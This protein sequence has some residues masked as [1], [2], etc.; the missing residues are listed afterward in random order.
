MTFR[1]PTLAA[2]ALMLMA[3]SQSTSGTPIQ[4]TSVGL[5]HDPESLIIAATNDRGVID[6]Q[7]PQGRV[8]GLLLPAVQTLRVPAVA[9]VEMGRTVLTSV[10]IQPG[11]RGR[12]WFVDRRGQRLTLTIP[13][14]GARVR[15]VLTEGAPIGGGASAGGSTRIGIP[16]PTIV[17][18]DGDIIHGTVDLLRTNGTQGD[19]G[20][21][22]EGRAGTRVDPRSPPPAPRTTGMEP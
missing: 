10:P 7:I 17:T 22:P 1:L 21:N 12:A 13:R 4:G 8:V 15:V 9:R 20:T 18:E 6:L 19:T 2:V 3:M 16:G 5:D 14:G 11:G